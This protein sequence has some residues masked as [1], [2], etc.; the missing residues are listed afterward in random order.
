VGKGDEMKK[1]ITVATKSII[2]FENVQTIETFPNRSEA[3]AFVM[4]T[5][6]LKRWC[7]HAICLDQHSYVAFP[8]SKGWAKLSI[9]S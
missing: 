1:A 6:N 2:F 5:A 9:I 7:G 8:G 4:K 3:I